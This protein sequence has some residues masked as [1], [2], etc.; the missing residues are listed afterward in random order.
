MLRG[1]FA[2]GKGPGTESVAGAA[3]VGE[4]VQ[5]VAE[6]DLTRIVEVGSAHAE[7]LVEGIEVRAVDGAVAVDVSGGARCRGGVAVATVDFTNAVLGEVRRVNGIVG[8][9]SKKQSE[10]AICGWPPLADA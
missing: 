7:E 1:R 4:D 8:L 2:V 10:K 6:V 5:H 3:E 9:L